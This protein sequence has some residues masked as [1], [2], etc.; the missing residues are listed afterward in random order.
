MLI[1]GLM[2]GKKLVLCS[3]ATCKS[4]FPALLEKPYAEIMLTMVEIRVIRVT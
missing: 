1:E 4:G 3:W 2:E